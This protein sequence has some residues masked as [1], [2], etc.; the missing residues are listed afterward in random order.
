MIKD[1]EEVRRDERRR[2]IEWFLTEVGGLYH[3]CMT[4]DCP[5]TDTQDCIDRLDKDIT[6]EQ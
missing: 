4:G 2:V 5:H 6:E 1:L 3:G